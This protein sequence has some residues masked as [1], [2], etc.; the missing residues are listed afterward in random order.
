VFLNVN[1]PHKQ[2]RKESHIVRLVAVW[3]IF[4]VIINTTFSA[5]AGGALTSE[6]TGSTAT[7]SS[8][9]TSLMP[10]M[11]VCKPLVGCFATEEQAKQARD[12]N[13]KAA[14]CVYL[15]DVCKKTPVSEDTQGPNSSADS[16]I[17]KQLWN[18]VS[19]KIQ[20]GYEFGKGIIAGLAGQIADILDLITNPGEVIDGL[21]NLGKALIADPEATLKALADLLGDE[22]KKTIQQAA[23]CGSYDKGY[24]IGSYISPA[25]GLKVLTKLAKY[26]G[27]AADLAKEINAIKKGLGCAS[28]IAGT[29]I[30][31][32]QGLIPIEQIHS[33]DMV[34]SRHEKLYK[35]S[36]QRVTQTFGRIA[37]SYRALKTEQET[38][39]LTDEHPLW[40]QG[41]GWTEAKDVQVDDVIAAKADDSLVLENTSINQ[42]IQ[43]YNFSVNKTASYFVG[44]SGLWAHNAKCD[45]I[46]GG[47]LSAH[48]GKKVGNSVAH[49][50]DRH[51]NVTT[52]DIIDRANGRGRW[53]SIDK[54][55]PP[56]VS[57][58]YKDRATAEFIIG[59]V[60]GDRKADINK[61][62]KQTNKPTEAFDSIKEFPNAIGEG[63]SRGSEAVQALKNARVI[64]KRDP[65]V[66]E[67]YI[68]LTSH[69]F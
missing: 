62:L 45:L 42:P 31:T 6:L 46:P 10:G 14:N 25:V 57:S 38:L 52:S 21:W 22:A 56:P 37:P 5:W 67:G 9:N 4:L 15:Q 69:P 1:K 63:V 12:A 18:G 39:Y 68:I 17:F 24:L 49:T 43:V 19:T 13:S 2:F 50:L 32:P 47:S 11:S 33:G 20:E 34:Q 64:L 48:E 55:G 41:K 53:A 36:E 7:T 54:N 60:I 66:P 35:D 65:S 16:N 8:Q 51:V 30:S 61:W 23:L 26:S 40:V 44:E 27:K 58:R 29:L 28:F 59:T 3:L